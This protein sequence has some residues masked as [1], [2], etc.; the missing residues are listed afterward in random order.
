M[1]LNYFK[2]KV[3]GRKKPPC[4][5]I[6]KTGWKCIKC[7]ELKSCLYEDVVDGLDSRLKIL[8]LNAYDDVEL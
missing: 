1:K 7:R 4:L 8:V 6:D 2:Y 5:M 3:F